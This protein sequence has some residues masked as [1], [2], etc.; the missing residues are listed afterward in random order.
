MLKD[1]ACPE[2][3]TA[4]FKDPKAVLQVGRSSIVTVVCRNKSNQVMR[5]GG[6]LVTPIFT[7]VKVKD[8]KVCDNNNGSYDTK[9]TAQDVGAVQF[10][11][12]INGHPAQRCSLTKKVTWTLRENIGTGVLSHGGLTFSSDRTFG[13][14]CFRVGQCCFETGV[15]SWTVEIKYSGGAGFSFKKEVDVGVID[16]DGDLSHGAVKN[17]HTSRWSATSSAEVIALVKLN[18]DHHVLSVQF[19]GGVDAKNRSTPPSQHR[20]DITVNR[21]CPYL[22]LQGKHLSLVVKQP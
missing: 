21:V 9:F 3:C 5:N 1:V 13:N 8:V 10:Q 14:W 15:H 6:Q 2:C 11:A 12:L 7:G 4:A 19:T 18:M 16:Y 22:A 17:G 20:F